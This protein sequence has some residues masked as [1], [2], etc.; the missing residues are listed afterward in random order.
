MNFNR[1]IMFLAVL[2]G[3]GLGAAYAS[4]TTAESAAMPPAFAASRLS[5]ELDS[6]PATSPTVSLN[7]SAVT[8]DNLWQR[9]RVGF[10][11]EPLDSPLVQEHEEW[12]TN[13]PDYIQR[14]VERG[15]KYLHHIVEEV[16]KRN[17]PME[18]ALLP[19]IESAFN[20]K[21][22]S[23]SKAAGMW[24]FIPSTGKNFGLKQDWQT[25]NRRDVLAST[26]AALNYLEKL[27]GMFNSWELALAAYN[28][29]E[30]CIARAIAT[31]QRK[32]LP[33][34]YLSLNLPLE[35]RNYVPK[36]I[37]VKNIILAPGS[38]GI[39]LEQL[40]DQPYFTTVKA[41]P[42][43]DVKLAAKLANMPEEEFVALNPA[44][45]RPVAAPQSGE[46]LLPLDKADVFRTNLESYDRPLVSWTTYNAKR[47]E[48]LDKIGRKYGV[49]GSY[50]RAVNVSLRER[51][52]KL[53]QPATIMVPMGAKGGFVK[54]V[55]ETKNAAAAPAPNAPA[56]HAPP[57]TYRVRQGDTLYGI[58]LKYDLTVDEIKDANNLRDS[59][60]SIGQVL[61]LNANT[62]AAAPAPAQAKT[63]TAPH[64]TKIALASAT[65]YT[66]R[67]GDT[68]FT[69]AQKFGV[70]LNDLLHWNKL[71]PKSVI[72]PGHKV[73]VSA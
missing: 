61:R 52:N 22:Y 28:C 5:P 55:F 72:Q 7:P 69:I 56:A 21:A 54:A 23:R 46:F 53:A 35:T 2:S 13:R 10:Q 26:H 16:E 41:P 39:E 31:N 51:R 66:I 45:N 27:H 42:K 19:V 20:P 64:L 48:S 8:D 33:T 18:I 49:S 11:L 71:S 29:G 73:R 17:M 70:A 44:F 38:Y 6:P 65:L 60:L 58:A 24:Q 36:L 57:A 14:F 63:E 68:L 62:V 30:G 15:S 43:I 12:Y 67:A 59:A 34:D 3:L 40:P 37:A 32:G 50:L 4:D 9:V 1:R 47:G 25:D